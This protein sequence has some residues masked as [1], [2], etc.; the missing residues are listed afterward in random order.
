MCSSSIGY[1]KNASRVGVQRVREP[2]ERSR[3]DLVVGVEH[4]HELASSRRDEIVPRAAEASVHD[5]LDQEPGQVGVL[6]EEVE[7]GLLGA[8]GR[9]I[10]ED[11]DLERLVLG[12]SHA[13]ERR[14]H[15]LRMVVERDQ[16]GD[17]WIRA[18]VRG[19]A[20]D[21]AY[22]VRVLAAKRDLLRGESPLQ[23]DLTEHQA[24][25]DG[26]RALAPL[27]QAPLALGRAR[28]AARSGPSAGR[29]GA[30]PGVGRVVRVRP[31]VARRARGERASV[32]RDRDQ[33]LCRGPH[34]QRRAHVVVR[35]ES[36]R[37]Q[38]LLVAEEVV[39]QQREVLERPR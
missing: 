20:N 18:R 8:V 25:E 33:P 13:G 2:V 19:S 28:R 29:S 38:P 15:L 39:G 6:G 12:G 24:L 22:L 1:A 10:V 26:V 23:L 37:R 9:S 36:H 16:H 17:A 14:A 5:V 32:F 7:D 11:D 27:S 30:G 35:R 3:V 31:R 34:G 21:D 4:E